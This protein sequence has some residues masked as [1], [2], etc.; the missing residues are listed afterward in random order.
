MNYDVWGSWSATTGPNAPLNDS[1]APTAEGSA[2]SAVK[3]WT[4]AGFPHGKII[5]GVASYG[6]S[7]HVNSSVAY[8]KSGKIDPYAPFDKALQPA[9]DK[10]DST[11]TGVDACGNPNVVGGLFDFWGLID[12]GF[13]TANGTAAKGIDYVFDPCSQTVSHQKDCFE[14]SF[15]KP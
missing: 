12:G 8:D 11:A 14:I 15:I 2:V 3:A 4:D 10:W 13:L 9:G 7:F 1:C 5:L 6:H